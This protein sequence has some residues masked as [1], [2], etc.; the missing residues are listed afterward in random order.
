MW[1]VLCAFETLR[2]A[3][4]A[5]ILS[6]AKAWCANAAT[7][8]SDSTGAR[9]HIPEVWFTRGECTGTSA[10]SIP[11]TV[12]E[13]TSAAGLSRLGLISA[14]RIGQRPI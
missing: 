14:S 2:Y 10:Q 4:E 7:D 3:Y 8:P 13:Q 11:R 5:L 12:K 6:T 1:W 9:G